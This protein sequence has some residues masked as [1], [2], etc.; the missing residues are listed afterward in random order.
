MK[1]LQRILSLSGLLGA[2]AAPLAAQTEPPAAVP[3]LESGV[4]LRITL[5]TTGE[6]KVSGPDTEKVYAAGVEVTRL[7]TK[8]FIA[9]L[10]EKYDLVDQPKDYA[11]VAVLVD[12]AT[13]DGYRF[14][15]KNIKK[16]GTPAYVY[17]APEVIGFTVNASASKYSEVYNGET[18]VGGGAK[19][20]HAVTLAT[21]GFSTQG[22]A[23]GG[24]KIADVTVE[25]VTAKL[26]V[27]SAMKVGTT[28][29]YTENP[30]TPE[31]RTYIAE[32]SWTFTAGKRVDLNDLPAPPAPAPET[33]AP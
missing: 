17:L 14:Y 2:L 6:E 21:A 31:A 16:N 32:T 19:F 33:P 3:A 9:L 15:L 20:K 22:V 1:N 23:T 5:T 27:P 24:Y 26:S 10:D 18:L 28:G 11:L 29:Y 25:G 30:G 13:E 8:D 12:T 4:N 7:N